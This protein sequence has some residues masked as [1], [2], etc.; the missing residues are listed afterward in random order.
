[1]ITSPAFP[2]AAF[3]PA[4][5]YV[6]AAY[7]RRPPFS[8]FLPG[9]AG[10]LG[11]PLWAFYVNRGQ[12]I[13]SFGIENKDHALL[14]FQPAN[15]AYRQTPLLGFRSFLKL[16]AS[17]NGLFYEPFALWAQGTPQRAM[18]IGLNELALVEQNAAVGLSTEVGYFIL[19]GEP[20]AALVRQVT[21]RNTGEQ[22]ITLEWLDGLPAL[23]PYGADNGA[24]KH[25][26]RTIEAWMQVEGHEQGLPFYRLRASAADTAEVTSIVAGHF[27]F[28]WLEQ[29]GGIQDAPVLVDPDRVFAQDTSLLQPAGFLAR[30]LSELLAT[31]QIASGKT[32]SAL[33]GAAATL[34]P[35]QSLTLTA[36][37]GHVSS[38]DSLLEHVQRLRDPALIARKR[39]EARDLAVQ[40]TDPIATRSALP[41][42]DGYCRQSF[43]DNVLRGG[44]PAWV[45]QPERP[46]VFYIYS[47]KHGDLERDYNDFFLAAEH[48]S[49]GNGNFRDV[50]QNRRNDVWFWPAAGDFNVRLHLS[51]IQIDG[52]NPLVLQGER[53]VI[54][55][56]FLPTLLEHCRQPRLLEPLLREPF[57]P[58]GL[59]KAIEDQALPLDL[60][61]NDFLALAL[62][63]AQPQV[64]AAYGEGYWIDHWT[65][66]LDLIESYAAIF[67]D[68]LRSLLFE[69]SLPYFVSPAAVQPRSEKYVLTDHGPRQY[70][71]VRPKAVP[72]TSW[73]LAG[74]GQGPVFQSRVIEKLFL[75][76]LLKFATR[77]PW[78]MGVEMEAGKP[79]WYD[80]LNGLPGLFGSSMPESYELLR[81]LRSLRTWLSDRPLLLRLPV[82]SEQLLREIMNALAT[83][84]A[85][86]FERWDAVASARE[87]YRR[88]TEAGVHGATAALPGTELV[89]F[90]DKMIED[91][92]RGIERASSLSD[93]LPPT[94]FAWEM[95]E[96][97]EQ[98]DASGQKRCDAEGRPLLRAR[99]FRP[100]PLPSFLEGPTRALKILSPAEA[101]Q[102]HRQMLSSPLWDAALGMFK[103]NAS[104]AGEP[105]EIGRARAFTPGWLENESIWLHMH[106]KY[107]L[108]L[109]RKG[110]FAEFFALAPSGLIP[111]RDAERYGRS[112]LENSSFLVSSAHPDPDLHG[113]GFVARLSGATAEFLHMWLLMM[114]GP[115]PFVLADG[116][117]VLRLRPALPGWLFA[118]DGALRWTF[119]GSCEITYHNAERR[120]CFPGAPRYSELHLDDGR[121]E[122]VAGPDIPP[123]YAA[124][125]RAG[126]VT[127]I[128][129]VL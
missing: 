42:F 92:E 4:G 74:Q 70:Q 129:V 126:R 7:D 22:E 95:T 54:S 100:R 117:L 9:I 101:R 87:Q 69:T 41:L 11:V 118:E 56:Q 102:L 94:Y 78:G 116:E 67:P 5:R 105:H 25:I 55:P 115:Q 32:P 124:M 62:S 128:D 18:H 96:F 121:V 34:A 50:V 38:R 45:G 3:D 43:L 122:H 120:D 24:L 109:L 123:P 51:L 6:L 30:P 31:P 72:P 82:E 21:L 12:A 58:G 119:L 76:A 39:E 19:P 47:R 103:V 63:Q 79:A 1:M 85:G 13:A 33:F 66:L 10:P 26:S 53:F 36:L 14:E 89:G 84:G 27:A 77:D 110:L 83:Y 75:L 127:R 107:L 61:A 113:R 98:L 15:K 52:Y 40:L 60:S 112:P 97:E 59:L 73:L 80:A 99:A 35:G 104:L 64:E 48:F 93:G 111:F 20:V 88:A 68:R 81:L 57:T 28:A 29:D 49:Q 106:Y 17:A 16:G 114:A 8:S 125:V 90:L 86:T 23:I 37:F 108:G 44:K 65:Y 2:T 91:V 46:H 71:A